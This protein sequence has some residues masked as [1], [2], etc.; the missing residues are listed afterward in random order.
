M[1]VPKPLD[2]SPCTACSHARCCFDYR[3]AVTPLDVARLV[4]GTGRSPLEFAFLLPRDGTDGIEM[5]PDGET[6]ELCLGK[7]ALP[8]GNG[9]VFLDGAVGSFRCGV[10][11][12][13]PMLCR[14]F[15]LRPTADGQFAAVGDPC[16]TGAWRAEHVDQAGAAALHQ[17][18]EAERKQSVEF[19]ERWN[20]IARCA[21][22]GKRRS[23][24]MFFY[25]V[26]T[27]FEST[28]PKLY[29]LDAALAEALRRG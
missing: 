18:W 3:V 11:A 14:S 21:P 2:T 1:T 12:H 15:P 25:W 6:F 17:R 8:S 16:P 26:V 27:V 20:R 23:L 13:R 28:P 22:A 24:R 10:H 4:Q 29:L 9:C 5:G 7:A 19:I